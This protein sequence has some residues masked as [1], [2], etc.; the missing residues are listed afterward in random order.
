[1]DAKDVLKNA[2]KA[3]KPMAKFAGKKVKNKVMSDQKHRQK[4]L[5]AERSKHAET[6]IRSHVV[7][8][9]GMAVIP[10]PL[11]DVFAVGA[12]Q[13][14]MIRQ[15][16]HVY[17]KEFSE[18]AGKAIATSLSSSILA[19]IGASS[20]IK[21]IPGIGTIVGGVT[22]SVLAGASTYALGEVFKTHFELGGTILDFDVDRLKKYYNE[23]F[24]KGKTIAK[25][26]KKEQDEMEKVQKSGGTIKVKV[27]TTTATTPTPEPQPETVVEP[28]KEPTVEATPAPS[29]SATDTTTTMDTSGGQA[30]S[31]SRD[32]IE[33]IRE[34]AELKS[35]GILT[36]EEFDM[37]KKKLIEQ[38]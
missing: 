12:A 6:I 31:D 3:I 15:L 13:L 25:Q 17:D 22:S 5:N 1:M 34:L 16:C 7:W 11:A 9:M 29:F 4:S 27:E 19:R 36:Q 38:M 14:D 30:A 2:Y 28:H 23:K 20:L 18:T 10:L 8:S 26:W 21:L 33:R 37:M 32:I 24:E 35:A